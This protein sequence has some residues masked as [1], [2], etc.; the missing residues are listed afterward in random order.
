MFSVLFV[1]YVCFI[2]FLSVVFLCIIYLMLINVKLNVM[3]LE[4]VEV[5]IFNHFIDGV[6]GFICFA[7][8]CRISLKIK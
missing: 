6:F 7:V 3:H 5:V 1:S 8:I 4:F 2:C